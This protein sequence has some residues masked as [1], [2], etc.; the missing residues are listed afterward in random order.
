MVNIVIRKLPIVLS[1]TDYVESTPYALGLN[2][3][4]R[5]VTQA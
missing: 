3:V 4:K 1:A 2:T 5:C